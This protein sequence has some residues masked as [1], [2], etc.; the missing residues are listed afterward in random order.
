[1]KYF[2][3]TILFWTGFPFCQAQNI[4]QVEYFIDDDQ[5]F[6]KNSLVNVAA[7]PDGPFP[8]TVNLSGVAPGQHQLY[9]RTKDSEGKWSVT[10]RRK[11]EIL[12]SVAPGKI[13]GGE[14]FFDTDAGMGAGL[15]IT[16]SPADSVI[17]QNY[18]AATGNLSPG[19]HKLYIRTRNS[20]GKWSITSRRNIEIIS[21]NLQKK[22]TGGEY[23]F[24]SDNGFN[25]GIP[26]I[27]TPQDSAI[28]QNF[29]TIT[30]S[31]PVGYHKLYIRLKDVDGNWSVTTRR[32]IEVINSA[33]YLITGAEYFFNTG[34]GSG[35]ATPVSFASPLAAGSFTFKIPIDKI[36]TGAHTLYI[37]ARD[38][39]SNNR[40][41]TLA[42]S[43]SVITS[44]QAGKW[45]NPAVWSNN[46]IPD[47]N[48]VVLLYHNVDIDI[49]N[50]VCKSLT[51]YRNNVTCHVEAGKSLR[52]SGSR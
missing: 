6:G 34:P 16:I 47:A 41:F 51:P 10:N 12:Q 28:L 48:T 13:V 19:Y 8:F 1:M 42:E 31:L 3:I 9:I 52:I 39:V 15:P 50:A 36:P 17:L 33:T 22:I 20:D 44:V 14:Y 25:A 5:G 4:V 26:I 40:G 45:S 37:R 23:F 32:N 35:N 21:N 24:D 30:S 18:T 2:L 46:K 27:V 49:I 29:A 11:I 43:D 38:S 7:S